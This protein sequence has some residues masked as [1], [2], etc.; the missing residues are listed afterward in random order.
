MTFSIRQLFIT[1]TKSVFGGQAYPFHYMAADIVNSDLLLCDLCESTTRILKPGRETTD[2]VIRLLSGHPSELVT[3]SSQAWLTWWQAAIIRQ[4]L[5]DG[6]RIRMLDMLGYA[7]PA[8]TADASDQSWLWAISTGSGY[9]LEELQKQIPIDLRNTPGYLPTL[10]AYVRAFG[11]L[12]S[13]SST[14]INGIHPIS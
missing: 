7:N 2:E 12:P 3:S 10:A 14:P 13:F 6:S 11:Q 5:P 1:P 8:R 4:Q 9:S